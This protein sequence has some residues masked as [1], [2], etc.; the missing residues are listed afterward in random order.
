MKPFMES[1]MELDHGSHL[2]H[3]LRTE[4]EIDTADTFAEHN[5]PGSQP[6]GCSLH[7]PVTAR[8]IRFSPER[9]DQYIDN[10]RRTNDHWFRSDNEGH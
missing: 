5:Q 8:C 9:V 7:S 10:G 1:F 2:N 4:D 6:A 3:C